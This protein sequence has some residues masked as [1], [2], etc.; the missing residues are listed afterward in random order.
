MRHHSKSTCVLLMLPMLLFMCILLWNIALPS[1]LRLSNEASRQTLGVATLSKEVIV[2]KDLTFAKNSFVSKDSTISQD[3]I[4]SKS[5]KIGQN[6]IVSKDFAIGQNSI[7][8]KDLTIGQNSI[9][10]KDLTIDKDSIVSRNTTY[11]LED[12]ITSWPRRVLFIWCGPKKREFTFKDFLSIKSAIQSVTPSTVLFVYKQL[13][14]LDDTKYNTWLEE[15]QKNFPFWVNRELS[16]TEDLCNSPKPLARASIESFIRHY[17]LSGCLFVG[18]STVMIPPFIL[19]EPDKYM[20]AYNEE[21]GQGFLYVPLNHNS[22][23]EAVSSSCPQVAH[24]NKSLPKTC[25]VINSSRLYPEQIMYSKTYV[26]E[27]LRLIYYGSKEIPLPRKDSSNAPAPNIAHYVWLRG[28]P[29]NYSFFVSVLSALYVGNVQYVYIHG[30]K[31]PSGP[32]WQKIQEN[33]GARVMYVPWHKP[34]KVFQQEIKFLHN[35]ADVYKSSIMADYGGIMMD[36][37]LYFVQQPDEE[38]FSYDTVLSPGF[39]TPKTSPYIFNMGITITK[40]HAKFAKLWLES[41]QDF[42]IEDHIWNCGKNTYKI[43]ERQ[44]EIAKVIWDFQI[45]CRFKVCERFWIYKNSFLEKKHKKKSLLHHIH[46][47]GKETLA[48]HVIQ[49]DPFNN[50]NETAYNLKTFEGEVGRLVLRAAGFLG[51]VDGLVP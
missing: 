33:G 28:G 22:Q 6:S 44:P 29:M 13:P 21:T 20:N 16:P 12:Y 32:N 38:L 50:Y 34:E 5:S 8:S 10:R 31:P 42:V 3:A 17:N 45:M 15:L 40:P 14:K 41:E 39:Y 4:V 2:S 43:W 49:P 37:D 1:E 19:N 36:P 46:E 9:V 18:D 27:Q 23:Q 11:K 48:V 25:M 51:Q 35:L 47:L 7:V 24:D 26:S 30:D